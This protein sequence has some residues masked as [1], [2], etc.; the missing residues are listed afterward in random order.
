MTGKEVTPM[1]LIGFLVGMV[2]LYAVAA[3]AAVF[4]VDS[5]DGNDWFN[6]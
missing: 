4:G 3:V 2:L 5:R 6:H 1:E